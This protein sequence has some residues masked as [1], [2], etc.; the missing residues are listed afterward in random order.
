MLLIA[1][2]RRIIGNNLPVQFKISCK[3]SVTVTSKVVKI[4]MQVLFRSTGA[5][6]FVHRVKKSYLCE[7]MVS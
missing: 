7:G 6:A 2:T 1:R 5:C 3:S 4:G